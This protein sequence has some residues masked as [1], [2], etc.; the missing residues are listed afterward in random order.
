M[1]CEKI[2]TQLSTYIDGELT[3]EESLFIREHISVCADCSQEEDSLRKTSDVLGFWE[4]VPAPDGFCEALL[5]KAEGISR[6][7]RRNLIHAVRP[8]AGPYAFIRVAFYGAALLLLCIG[9]ILF[10]WLPLKK[11]P[12]VEPLSTYSIYSDEYTTYTVYNNY[13]TPAL[14]KTEK[15][16]QNPKSLPRYTTMAEMKTAGIW[17]SEDQNL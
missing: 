2:K 8:L 3:E 13:N 12:M 7:P 15:T 14:H 1:D 9:L 10:V 5:A 4:N 17:K 11:A 6:Q 16:V